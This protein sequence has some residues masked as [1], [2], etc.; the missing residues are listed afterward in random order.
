MLRKLQVG[1]TLWCRIKGGSMEAPTP[2]QPVLCAGIGSGV[3]PH[4]AFLRDRVQAAERKEEV[5]PYSLYFGNR[6]R[7]DE[8]LFQKELEEY[9]AKYPWFHLH[10]AFSRD[11]PKKKVY[12]QDVRLTS[13]CCLVSCFVWNR[14]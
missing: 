9:D 13:M 12:V 3:A 4:M 6:S 5:A 2:S 8:Y 1:D 7:A 10:M 14:I 11:D